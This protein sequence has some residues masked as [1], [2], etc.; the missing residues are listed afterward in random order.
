M[1]T[2]IFG[3]DLPDLSDRSWLIESYPRSFSYA[4]AVLGLHRMESRIGNQDESAEFVEVEHPRASGGVAAAADGKFTGTDPRIGNRA[5][6]PTEAQAAAGNYRKDH[7]TW[8][9]LGIAI[10]TNK[11][12]VR[13]GTGP[14][15]TKWSVTMPADYGYLKRTEGADGDHVDVYMG[16]HP[17]SQRVF[18]VDQVHADAGHFDEHKCMLGFDSEAVALRAYHAAFDAGRGH[19]R[20]G[21]VTELSVD[22]FLEWLE[23]GDTLKPVGETI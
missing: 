2:A 14:D 18:V 4:D 16:E 6:V 10:E 19:D 3:D 5:A 12:G 1:T 13:S 17:E 9:G 23:H 22:E 20:V 15:G 7:L 8:N 21:A 11:G